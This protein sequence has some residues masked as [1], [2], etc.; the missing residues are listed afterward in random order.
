MA[1][2]L[3][4]TAA[5][6]D[7]IPVDEAHF[8][9]PALRTY[10]LNHF[11][12]DKNGALDEAERNEVTAIAIYSA[13][14]RSFQGIEVF[15]HLEKLDCIDNELTSL[16]V[17]DLP[18][19]LELDCSEN[20][21]SSLDV[22]R[23]PNLEYLRCNSCGLT[24][25][26]VSQNSGLKYLYCA[27]NRLTSLNVRNLPRLTDLTCS[28][29]RL[30]SLYLDENE[31]L[32]NLNCEGNQ[33]SVQAVDGAFDLSTLPGFELIRSQDFTGG[34]L[35]G[36]VLTVKKN[37]KV[38][39]T[40]ACGAGFSRTFILDM[41]VT[42]SQPV[43][44][45]LIDDEHFPDGAFRAYVYDNLDTD[46][47][48]ALSDAERNAVTRII[49]NQKSLSSLQGIEYFPALE[50]LSCSS[51][52][53]KSIDVS[54][55][56]KLQTLNCNSNGLSSLDVSGNRALTHLECSN[57]QLTRL[58]LNGNP[59]LRHLGC[60]SNPLGSL[61][62]SHNPALEEV[63]CEYD[64]LS[65]LDVSQNPNLAY[66]DCFG[67]FL[68]VLDVSQN[69]KLATLMCGDCRLAALDVSRNPA[70]TTLYG[71]QRTLMIEAY[72]KQFD[73]NTLPGFDVTKSS[74]WTVGTVSGHILTVPD[75]CK[76]TYDYDCGRGKKITCTMRV[77][78]IMEDPADKPGNVNGDEAGAVDGRD[79]L[80]LAKYLA[81]EGVQINEK[82]ADVNAD[83]TVDGRDLIRLARYLAGDGVELKQAP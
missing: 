72:N 7:E 80:R 62:L 1:V 22:S 55:L 36:S 53:L 43:Q 3:C 79:V 8:P 59:G 47:N 46:H 20:P 32:L 14:V 57:N 40:Y 60:S 48:G 44:G 23:F 65:A 12:A 63:W 51:C 42:T 68:T 56:P 77:N 31:D 82:A 28:G 37:E 39:Y 64:Q 6:A 50:L 26:D 10:I 76:V 21:L 75:V 38:Y 9:D 27:N 15:P 25:L 29:N 81:G 24:S 74:N 33:R 61:D 41:I 11:D 54:A 49:I 52:G 4:W 71:D 5:L 16:G 35:N 70:L 18:S 69:Q 83:G 13:G 73:L 45:L 67:N 78:L 17:T 19:L 2:L 58:N 66:L 34:E 30:T